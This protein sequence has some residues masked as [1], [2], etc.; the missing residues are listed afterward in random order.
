MAKQYHPA[1]IGD[2]QDIDPKPVG[3]NRTAVVV[4]RHLHDLI[5]CA[6][7]LLQ[8]A[9]RDFFSFAGN[10]RH[11]DFPPGAALVLYASRQ[12]ICLFHFRIASYSTPE[13]TVKEIIL[14]N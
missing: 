1:G 8:F 9:D 3:D 2:A 5:L 4:N 6:H 12:I 7:F 10:F 13:L 11:L 14:M